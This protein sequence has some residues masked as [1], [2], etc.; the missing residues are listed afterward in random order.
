MRTPGV[1]SGLGLTEDAAGTQVEE[2]HSLPLPK[3]SFLQRG[4]GGPLCL[5]RQCALCRQRFPHHRLTD[6]KDTQTNIS[7]ATPFVTTMA[8]DTGF[9]GQK[10][11]REV[12]ADGPKQ[13]FAQSMVC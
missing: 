11:L 8:T 5:S 13:V 3:L 9:S 7:K 4:S 10:S 2:P 1:D 6:R 12:L